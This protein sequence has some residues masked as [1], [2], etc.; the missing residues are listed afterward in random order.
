MAKV[1]SMQYKRRSINWY[2]VLFDIKDDSLRRRYF[3]FRI[4][5]PGMSANRCAYYVLQKAYSTTT[6]SRV[7]EFASAH[8]GVFNVMWF[9]PPLRCRHV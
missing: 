1:L 4:T 5:H 3:H 2:R 9:F 7:K 6:L 8:N